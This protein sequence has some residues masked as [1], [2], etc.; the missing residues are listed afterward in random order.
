MKA[1]SEAVS[2]SCAACFVSSAGMLVVGVVELRCA[3]AQVGNLVA[4]SF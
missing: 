1:L 4:H 2:L 3:I